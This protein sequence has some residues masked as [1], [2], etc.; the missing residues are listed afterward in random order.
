MEYKTVSSHT[1]PA[2]LP[3]SLWPKLSVPSINTNRARPVLKRA[4]L[5]PVVR[6]RPEPELR[7]D[8]RVQSHRRSKKRRAP[9][10]QTGK[11]ARPL[12]QGPKPTE[13]LSPADHTEPRS[14]TT[15]PPLQGMKMTP[16]FAPMVQAQGK[17]L[18][19]PSACVN[20]H[21]F[22]E[23]LRKWETG[24]PVDCGKP[25]TWETIEAAVPPLNP[26][27]I[28]FGGLHPPFSTHPPGIALPGEWVF[29]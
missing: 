29:L 25:W 23:T 12:W 7:R 19:S 18:M 11:R 26:A 22:V 24:V 1:R 10:L 15:K 21:P 13:Q 27:A 9:P 3:V 5:R 17:R 14:R 20:F 6:S 2:P 8:I 28:A 16:K 4:Q